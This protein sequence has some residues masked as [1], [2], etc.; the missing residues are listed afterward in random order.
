MV[1]QGLA[2]SAGVPASVAAVTLGLPRGDCAAR[3][4]AVAEGGKE[5]AGAVVAPL[6][7][8]RAGLGATLGGHGYGVSRYSLHPREA[9]MVVRCL[10][11]RDEQLRRCRNTAQP[12]TL[13]ELYSDPEVLAA[14]PYFS[15]VLDI[16]NNIALRPATASGKDYPDVSRAYFEAV[17]VVLTGKKSAT[18]AAADL[19]VELQKITGLRAPGKGVNATP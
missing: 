7:A 16:R 5:R 14:N 2:D 10:C 4:R 6:P 1:T 8:G 13:P 19:Q 9:A 11:R 15:T 18:Q 3:G 12:P 17:H